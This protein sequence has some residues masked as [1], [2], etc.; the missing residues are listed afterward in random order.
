MPTQPLDTPT[1]D[2]VVRLLGLEPLPHEGGFF[3][4]TYRAATTIEHAA[5]PPWYPASPPTRSH[6]TQIYYL[7]RPGHTS[8]MHRVLS[9]E[10]FHFYLGDPVLQLVIDVPRAHSGL[11]VLGQDVVRGQVPQRVVAAGLW[12]GAC[13]LSDAPEP[14]ARPFVEGLRQPST[15]HGF[16]LLGCTVAPGF[17][18]ADFELMR[19]EQAPALRELDPATA[20]LVDLLTP[21]EGRTRA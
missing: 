16:A 11:G 12:Q 19:A 21:A 2:E 1:A 20:P 14:I 6:A 7:L 4:E 8:A 15:R 9:D 3:R 10:C 5:L 18:W 17:D 13:L